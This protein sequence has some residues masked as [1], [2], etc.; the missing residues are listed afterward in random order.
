MAIDP[1]AGRP[2]IHSVKY[3]PEMLN[4]GVAK[5]RMTRPGLEV[6]VWV[7]AVFG[8]MALGMIPLYLFVP[9]LSK[10]GGNLT[11]TKLALLGLGVE[12]G[13]VSPTLAAFLV[14]RF[15]P[16]AGGVRALVRQL[17]RWR[18][19]VR[20]YAVA[21]L[22]P[23]PIL[24]AADL[25]WIALGK[26]LDVWF[27][28]PTGTAAA[29][30]IGAS[31]VPPFGEEFGWRG[32]AQ[33]RLQ[34]RFGALLAA[35]IVGVMWSTWHLWPL[36]VPGGAKLF[37]PSDV[38]QTYVRLIGTAIIY[39]WI[40]NST[41]GNLVAVIIAHAGHNIWTSFIPGASNDPTHLGPVIGSVLYFAVAIG[42][43]LATN[44][45]TLT[46]PPRQDASNVGLSKPDASRS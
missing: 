26:N 35:L 22:L 37:L 14:A 4:R 33:P 3:A 46:R 13:A 11:P 32:F 30:S 20:W 41:G 15:M 23:V 34:Q 19:P 29:F 28:V 44:R 5:P 7:G 27:M 10:F 42:V 24:L 17:K 6:L 40:Y 38:V 9:D 12:L 31:I 39:A 1:S 21:L 8:L 16:G 36:A 45:R 25:I 43:V 2:R 18:A